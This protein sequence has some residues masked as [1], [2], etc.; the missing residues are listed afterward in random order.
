M[1]EVLA[2]ADAMESSERL[3]NDS[4]TTGVLGKRC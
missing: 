4:V 3:L 2:E 1:S